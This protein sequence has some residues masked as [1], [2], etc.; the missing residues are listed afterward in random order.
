MRPEGAEKQKAES[1]KQN[2]AFIRVVGVVCGLDRK[3]RED[4]GT[5]RPYDIS[6]GG[7]REG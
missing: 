6:D 7:E 2:A 3:K 4:Y 5:I 1:K